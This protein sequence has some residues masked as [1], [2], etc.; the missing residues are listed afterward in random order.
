[1][2]DRCE[3]AREVGVG[4]PTAHRLVASADGLARRGGHGAVEAVGVRAGR[5]CWPAMKKC[6]EKKRLGKAA[7]FISQG[8]PTGGAWD[9]AGWTGTALG[10]PMRPLRVCGGRRCVYHLEPPRASTSRG[11]HRPCRA[12]RHPA[13]LTPLAVLPTCSSDVDLGEQGHQ[14]CGPRRRRVRRAVPPRVRRARRQQVPKGGWRA[15]FFCFFCFWPVQCL[16]PP[17]RA[18]CVSRGRGGGGESRPST[19]STRALVA[20]GSA[21]SGGGAAEARR[22]RY[23]SF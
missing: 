7:I 6:G 10:R 13:H 3:C 11:G 14:G 16:T 19:V 17:V 20:E 9:S 15:C 4:E 5:F 22:V 23:G 12:S 1:M 18:F 8:A 2:L 21:A